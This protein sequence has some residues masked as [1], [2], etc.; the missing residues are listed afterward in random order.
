[1][2]CSVFAEGMVFVHRGSDGKGVAPGDVCLSPP[3]Q[4]GVPA[5]YVNMLVIFIDADA[6]AN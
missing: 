3:P 2:S 5:P 1:V 6:V 4:P